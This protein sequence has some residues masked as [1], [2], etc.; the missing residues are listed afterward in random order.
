MLKYL[1]SSL[2]A[3]VWL[4]G[5]GSNDCCDANTTEVTPK[6]EVEAPKIAPTALISS[7]S[8]KCV[9]GGV[10]TFDGRSS[11][12]EDGHVKEYTWMM[13]SKVVSS[14]AKPTFSCDSLGEK[15][16]CLE[17][18]DDDNLTSSKVCQTYIVEAA[19]KIAPK[20]VIDADKKLCTQGDTIVVDGS[21][22]SDSD[23]EVVRY[24]WTYEG[25]Q[26]SNLQK[27][28]FDCT[29][30]GE[31]ELCLSVY[32]NDDLVDK[33]C[34]TIVGQAV[35]NKA[36]ISDLNVSKAT[37]LL[38]E[39]VIFDASKSKDEDGQIMQ[40][41]WN[42]AGFSGVSNEFNCSEA[43]THEVCVTV[44]DDKGINSLKSC[45]SVV[46]SKPANIPPVAN[47]EVLP[48]ECTVGESVLGDA[49]TSSDVDGNVTAYLWSVDANE[50]A[51]IE[52]KPIFACDKVG[53]KHI[54]LK[55]TDNEGATSTNQACKDVTV[56]E[57][58]IQT[59]PPV[60]KITV[61]KN[62]DDDTPSVTAK[63]DGSYDPDTVDSDNNPQNDGKIL[64]AVFT[65]SKT[66]QDGSK[67][68]PH[69]GTCP[70]WISTPADL[71]SMTIS[72][73]VTDD[74][75]ESTTKTEIYDWDGDK[76]NLRQ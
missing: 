40:Y 76:L 1:L 6:G 34:T 66:F 30:L 12:D 8:Q 67:E 43:G 9:E 42:E 27:T 48:Q 21:K 41:N 10:I 3:T 55:V 5:C 74:D 35:P 60:A 36:P 17:V 58:V 20:A 73:T 46:V 19:P 47:I 71:K 33:N 11:A 56:K 54:C 51:S 44:V 64:T 72:L 25:D 32:D 22:S 24:A 53:I 49:T 16:V 45:K 37:C 28:T 39:S 31:Q 26:N 14:S 63:C 2:I 38:G 23:G 4:S 75:G 18:T 62:V 65:V 68:D 29:K 69:T 15:E 61:D 59:I 7:T 50:S 57:K 70:K 13:D 52:P